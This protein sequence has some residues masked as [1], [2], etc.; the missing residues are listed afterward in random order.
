MNTRFEIA[1]E[2][3]A[4]AHADEV[5]LWFVVARIRDEVGDADLDRLQRETLDCVDL[6]LASGDVSAGSYRPDGSGLEL[7]HRDRQDILNRI[8]DEWNKLGR[9]PDIGDI[10]VFV[11]RHGATSLP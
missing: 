5:G 4:E 10:V 1:K 11:G 9:I 2:L 7:W 8:A 3:I 6:M